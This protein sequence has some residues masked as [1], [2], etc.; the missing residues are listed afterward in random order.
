MS[1]NFRKAADN[2]KKDLNN[3]YVGAIVLSPGGGGKSSLMGT[4]EGKTLYLY[5]GD[6][7][8]GPAAAA[9]NGGEVIA[10]RVDEDDDGGKLTPDQSYS[11]LLEL[12]TA[13]E[14]IRDEG[15][16]AIVIDSLTAF[17]TLIRAT[18]KFRAA[19][20]T[21]KG[22]HNKFAEPQ[23]VLD[24]FRPILVKLRDLQLNLGVHYACSCPLDV[25]AMGDNGEIMESKPKLSTFSVAEGLVLQ[26]PDV[27]V[28]GRMVKDEKSSWRIQ[29][30]AGVSKASKD[31]SGATKKCINF[32]P[33]IMGIQNLPANMPA[34]MQK[35]AELKAKRGEK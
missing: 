22:T 9:A 30:N 7:S 1:F 11:R 20:M 23:A 13:E 12:L 18:S 24:L 35:V 14:G 29:F 10:V 31:Q 2:A 32:N 33:R 6:E 8:H 28:V 15:F 25:V 26:F 4:F 19:C 16:K 27:L 3:P 21:D 5:T 34:N 17:E